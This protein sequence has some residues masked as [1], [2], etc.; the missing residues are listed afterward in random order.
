MFPNQACLKGFLL[1]LKECLQVFRP[2]GS[3]NAVARPSGSLN[4]APAGSPSVSVRFPQPLT[5]GSLSI[6]CSNF[7]VA[8]CDPRFLIH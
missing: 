1:M 3:P 8:L 4:A 2:S 6:D 7:F 5:P